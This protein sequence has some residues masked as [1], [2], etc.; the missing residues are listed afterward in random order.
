MALNIHSVTGRFPKTWGAEVQFERPG[1]DDPWSDGLGPSTFFVVKDCLYSAGHSDGIIDFAEDV[2]GTQGIIY[3]PVK[4][5][6]RP[7]DKG[8][9][10]ETAYSHSFAFVVGG[11]PKQFPYGM[12]IPVRWEM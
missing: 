11:W 5:D 6:I 4:Q 1:A 10:P 2:P 8:V 9:W 7:Q 3:T 12:A